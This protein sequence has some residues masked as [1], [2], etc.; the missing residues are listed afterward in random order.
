MSA[1]VRGWRG[2]RYQG[3]TC[4]RFKTLGWT[5]TGQE[6]W[7]TIWEPPSDIAELLPEGARVLGE[8][9]KLGSPEAAGNRMSM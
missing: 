7:L 2:G 5:S 4:E 6:L 8:S 3:T 9:L 1:G